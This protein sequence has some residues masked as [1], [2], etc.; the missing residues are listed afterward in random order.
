MSYWKFL[1]DEK[2][3]RK[4]ACIMSFETDYRYKPKKSTYEKN[5]T[6]G[7]RDND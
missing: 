2:K 6:D 1:L 5:S 7:N 4:R 3:I